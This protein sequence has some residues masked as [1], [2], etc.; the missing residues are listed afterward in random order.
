MKNIL[1]SLPPLHSIHGPSYV[2]SESLIS[3]NFSILKHVSHLLAPISLDTYRTN[4]HHNNSAVAR[5][6][7]RFICKVES[8][9]DVSHIKVLK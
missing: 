7:D 9:H 1:D 3:A 6:L 4:N 5:L 2:T 8:Y